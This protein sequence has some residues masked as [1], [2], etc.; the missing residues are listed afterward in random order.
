MS[1]SHQ[2]LRFSL[3][4]QVKPLWQIEYQS[5]AQKVLSPEDGFPDVATFML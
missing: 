4:T 5:L 2:G 3:G 1:G